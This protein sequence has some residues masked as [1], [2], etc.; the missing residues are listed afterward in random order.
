MTN[1][2]PEVTQGGQLPLGS[3]GGD[4]KGVLPLDGVSLVEGLGDGRG[5]GPQG[6]EIEVSGTIQQVHEDAH[7]RVLSR[8][9]GLHA[10]KMKPGVVD[11]RSEQ[12]GETAGQS[13]SALARILARLM[14]CHGRSSS[15]TC[16]RRGRGARAPRRSDRAGSDACVRRLSGD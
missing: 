5:H 10:L 13:V 11:D 8:P 9:G 12:I 14:G 16:P 2:T 7:D 1:G 3:G 15:R 6:V 4:L